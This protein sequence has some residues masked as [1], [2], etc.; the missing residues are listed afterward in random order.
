[1]T[2]RTGR[3]PFGG[4][5]DPGVGREPGPDALR[6]VTETENVFIHTEE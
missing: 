5:G 4:F 2:E 3:T 1:M 6:H